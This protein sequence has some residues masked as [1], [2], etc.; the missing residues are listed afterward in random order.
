MLIP[1]F[2]DAQITTFTP[3]CAGSNDTAVFS[4]IVSTIG[5]NTG[6]IRLPYKNGSRCA[7][8]SLTIPANITLDNSD[9][10]G[11]KVNTGQTLTVV[12]PVKGPASLLFSNALSGQGKVSFSGNRSLT[13]VYPQWWGV[14][15]DKV[16]DDTAAF[17][18]CI[19]AAPDFSTL[20]LTNLAIKV[21]ATINIHGRYGL[22]IVS[23]MQPGSATNQSILAAAALHWYGAAGGTVLSINKS[24]SLYIRGL[25]INAKGGS[26]G[27]N[28]CIDI[29]QTDGAVTGTMTDCIFEKIKVEYPGVNA[30]FVGVRLAYISANNVED[31]RFKDCQFVGSYSSSPP[32]G[33]GVQIG[34]GGGGSNAFGILFEDCT[35]QQCD[36]GM[37]A[38]QGQ[39]F[40]SGGFTTSNNIDF[41]TG[42]GN[43]EMCVE[44][45]SSE[46]AQQA[47]V[48]NGGKFTYRGNRVGGPVTPRGTAL[49]HLGGH[50]A[51][52]FE[53]NSIDASDTLKVF[54]A[55]TTD[56]LI[57]SFNTYPNGD[58]AK[59]NFSAFR[60]YETRF[61]RYGGSISTLVPPLGE[62]SIGAR[63][64]FATRRYG[65]DVA[66]PK[67][68]AVTGFN[69]AIGGASSDFIG[70][71]GIASNASGVTTNLVGVEGQVTLTGVGVQPNTIAFR[72]ATPS[73]GPQ[74]ATN[75]YGLYVEAQQ[76]AGVTKGYG[77]YQA[78]AS[79]TNYLAGSTK[80]GGGAAIKKHLSATATWDPAKVSDG[81]ITST[82]VNV[83][84]AVVGD[85][86]AVGFS[87]AVPAGALLSGAVTASDTVSVT[88][89]N[90][91]G[92]PLDLTSGTL[93]ADVWQH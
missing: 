32:S 44:N 23:S 86:V 60:R 14:V 92:S 59:L 52:T 67:V 7:V 65:G 40:V 19:D 29:D 31:I 91:T 11:L 81:A 80:L 37:K 47:L 25:S 28:V 15:G 82:T 69:S 20:L 55:T 58:A 68:A 39:I 93:R 61:D 63:A 5:S 77:L 66:G 49:I 21:T 36:I 51:L 22:R 54:D 87:Q 85:T 34:G 70:V 10:T 45:I 30:S 24:T 88:L 27:A 62:V 4:A 3:N 84:G 74:L 75:S 9:G 76:V 46:M 71:N 1:V 8:N 41:Y 26:N 72:A 78:G 50:V 90:K 33:V 64:T 48:L 43:P 83:A 13:E 12:G 57:S 79:D 6:T 18:A 89:F 53:H 38:I 17:Q 35:I 73:M 42:N 56:D 16:A 2:A